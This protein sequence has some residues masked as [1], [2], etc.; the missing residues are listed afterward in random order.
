MSV[1]VGA[2]DVG[3]DH[4][5]AGVGLLARDA[6]PVAVAGRGQWV[7]REHLPLALPQQR[8]QQAARGLDRDRNRVLLAVAVLGEQFQQQSVA[9]H[10]VGGVPLGR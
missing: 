7:D 1:H 5:V 3:Q 6:V 9:G 8:N 2:Q 10:V 4:G